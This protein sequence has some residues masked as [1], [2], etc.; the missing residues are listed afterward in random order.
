MPIHD[1]RA[2]RIFV[3]ATLEQGAN[4]PCSKDQAHY[5]R[6]VLRVEDRAHV[7]VF[8]GQD[9][10]WKTQ[11]RFDGKRGCDLVVESQVRAQETGPD[12]ELIFAPLKRARLDYLVQKATEL[13][14]AALR[15]VFTE[16]TVP[17]RIKDTRLRAN[18]VEA[19][20]QCGILYLPTLAA[21]QRLGVLLDGWDKD[22]AIFFCDEAADTSNP[23]E[24]L[25]RLRRGEP[26]SVLIG[27][28]GGFSETERARLL[29]LDFVT[30]LSLGPRI[31]R[32]DTAAIAALAL[33]NATIGDWACNNSLP[34]A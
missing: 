2:Q 26:A 12:V 23:I 24:T 16:H 9:G 5:L 4:V 1:F 31:M 14:V 29:S 28:E 10:E 22:R 20:E 27:P 6:N 17:D 34:Y 13:G 33:L 15:P 8:N 30:P 25:T 3:D 32:A 21:P 19:A 11:I 7:L 18:I